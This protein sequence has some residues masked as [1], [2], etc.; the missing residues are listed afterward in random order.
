MEDASDLFGLR[1]G[2]LPGTSS[3]SESRN[4]FLFPLEASLWRP[5]GHSRHRMW[6]CLEQLAAQ[7]CTPPGFLH[8]YSAAPSETGISYTLTTTSV[9]DKTRFM[10]CV[11]VKSTVTTVRV[12]CRQLVWG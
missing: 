12:S 9:S 10:V 7:V 3:S 11:H 4:L 1:S 6:L 8:S 2:A 5:V